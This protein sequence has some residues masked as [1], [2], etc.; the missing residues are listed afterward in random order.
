[1]K[2]HKTAKLFRTDKIRIYGGNKMKKNINPVALEVKYSAATNVNDARRA[3][4]LPGHQCF[5]LF[6]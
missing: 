3:E 4:R 1:M 5:E 6:S 2:I